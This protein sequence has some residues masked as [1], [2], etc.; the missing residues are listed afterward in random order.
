MNCVRACVAIALFLQG[1]QPIAPMTNAQI[2][3]ATKQCTDAGLK[4]DAYYP[5]AFSG[6]E[7]IVAIQCAP[8]I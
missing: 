4:A 7:R 5:G 6:D 1:C 3:A 2:I 8:K